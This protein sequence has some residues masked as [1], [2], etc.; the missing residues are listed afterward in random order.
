MEIAKLRS[1]TDLSYAD[2]N[3]SSDFIVKQLCFGT[4]PSRLLVLGLGLDC[5]HK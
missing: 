5:S 4:G 3:K 1:T 2:I